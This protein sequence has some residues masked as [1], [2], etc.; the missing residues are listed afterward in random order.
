MN[1]VT[2]PEEYDPD[3]LLVVE[4]N[5][6]LGDEVSMKVALK[7]LNQ[8]KKFANLTSDTPIYADTAELLNLPLVSTMSSKH[9]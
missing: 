1:I 8:L 2:E 9:A 3:A 5:E 7:M 4:P 6:F